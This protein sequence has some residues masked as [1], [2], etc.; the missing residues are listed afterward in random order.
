MGAC[1]LCQAGT[2]STSSG[3]LWA[4][5]Q[6]LVSG[7]HPSDIEEERCL[8]KRMAIAEP[9]SNISCENRLDGGWLL[10]WE[11]SAA[12]L[13]RWPIQWLGTCRPCDCV[14]IDRRCYLFGLRPVPGRD[15]LDWIR[16]A[17]LGWLGS[18][19]TG[20]RDLIAPKL[21][22]CPCVMR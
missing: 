9:S 18:S 11:G 6:G 1:S 22:L 14:W 17:A 19:L 15:V 20:H 8:Y 12:A 5:A 7:A 3:G 16:L 2:F 21:G 10:D 4:E 13:C